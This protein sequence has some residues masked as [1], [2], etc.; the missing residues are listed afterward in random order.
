MNTDNGKINSVIFLDIR[1][2]FGTVNHEILLQ[3]LSSYRIK[4]DTHKFLSLTQKIEYNVAVSMVI[5]HP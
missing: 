3:K 2:A 5:Y 4:G 1:K